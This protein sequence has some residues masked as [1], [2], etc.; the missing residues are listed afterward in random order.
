VWDYRAD[1]S[2]ALRRQRKRQ[3]GFVGGQTGRGTAD[4]MLICS[5]LTHSRTYAMFPSPGKR[6]LV[7]ECLVCYN[8]RVMNI[9]TGHFKT[10]QPGSNQN[11][12]L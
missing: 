2:I 4:E 9:V 12:P 6:K 10:S 7:K 8:S 3:G 11:R 1:L 5:R